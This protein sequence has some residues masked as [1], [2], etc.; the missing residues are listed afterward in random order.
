[1]EHE[2]AG[3]AIENAL[4]Y[5]RGELALCF[6]G[7]LT[8]FVDVGP[9]IF[10]A[11]HRAFDSHDLKQLQNGGVADG[12]VGT[13]RLVDLANCAWATLPNNTENF[14]LPG[15]WPLFSAPRGCH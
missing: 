12:F 14:Q 13:E 10:V 4:Q 3:G 5:V 9:L 11:A 6:F 8:G 1:M 7:G 15:R 2:L